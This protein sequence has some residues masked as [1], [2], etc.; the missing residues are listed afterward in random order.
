MR[1][2]AGE[3]PVDAHV[4]G[5]LRLFRLRAGM[6]QTA[7]A[8]RIGLTF[9]QLQKYE[10]GTNRI[11]ASTLLAF[12][13]IL[14]VPVQRFF[15]GLTGPRTSGSA[16]SPPVLPS[17]LDYEIF[18]LVSRLA[19]DDVK[20]HFRDLLSALAAGKGRTR[21]PSRATRARRPSA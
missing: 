10:K 3:R 18:Q 7:L 20:R 1:P 14:D 9:Q 2:E 19:D 8:D 17:R 6:S 11:S 16:M 13:Q 4:G 12:S 15:E 21:P 5:R